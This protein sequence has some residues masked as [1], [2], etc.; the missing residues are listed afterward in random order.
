MGE[1]TFTVEEVAKRLNITPRTLHYYEE[2]GLICPATRTAGGHR[3]YNDRVVEKL[4]RILRMKESLGISLQEIREIL[5]VEDALEQLRVSFEE[6][7]NI[8]EKKSIVDEYIQLL[9][10]VIAKIDDKIASLNEMRKNFAE[11]VQRTVDLKTSLSNEN[12]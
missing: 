5:D 4:S 7:N 8:M 10:G 2:M 9:A 6:K 3:L 11:R 1:H 12:E